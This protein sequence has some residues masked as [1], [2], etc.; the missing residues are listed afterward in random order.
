MIHVLRH[1]AEELTVE[2]VELARHGAS[3]VEAGV[4]LARLLEPT[5]RAFASGHARQRHDRQRL[6]ALITLEDVRLRSRLGCR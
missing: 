2:S 4:R 3:F 6:S 1:P 5:R